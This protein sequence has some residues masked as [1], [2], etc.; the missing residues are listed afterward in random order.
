MGSHTGE[1]NPLSLCTAQG[2]LFFFSP[3]FFFSIVMFA[4]YKSLALSI[5][6]L[7]HIQI[8]VSYQ[9]C[10]VLAKYAMHISGLLKL[11]KTYI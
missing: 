9:F 11:S 2:L 5:L 10:K 3:Y 1:M 6:Q 7:V 4:L 8:G